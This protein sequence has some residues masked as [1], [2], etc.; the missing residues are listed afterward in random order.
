M[1]EY[2]DLIYIDW[3]LIFTIGNTLILFF[4]LKHFFYDKVKK[5]LNSREEE[6]QKIY[7]TA[8]DANKTAQSMKINYETQIAT[9]KE[10]SAE[11]IKTATKKAQSRTDDMLLQAQEKASAMLLRAESQIEIEKKKAVNEIKDEMADLA[12]SAAE[13]VLKKEMNTADN[14][15]LINDFIENAGDI[16]WQN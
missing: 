13:Q 3:N 15:K 7:D 1:G 12:I 11:I 4:V 8:N 9:V 16:K 14:E 10:Q 2:K 5:V 6:I